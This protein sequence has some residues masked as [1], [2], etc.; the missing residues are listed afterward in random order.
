[1]LLKPSRLD[2]AVRQF[3]RRRLRRTTRQA[4]VRALALVSSQLRK[5]AYARDGG[6]CRVT[7]VPLK[8]VSDNPELVAHGHHVIFRSAGGADELWNIA[9]VSPRVH[10]RIHQHQYDVEGNAN[11]TLICRE[12]DLETGKILREWESR[13]P[14]EAHKETRP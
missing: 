14:S 12:R 5:E 7:G 10:E 8:L 1:M 6:C 11:D 4:K 9:I 2:R 13:C 3:Q